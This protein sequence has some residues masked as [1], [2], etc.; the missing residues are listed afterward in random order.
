MLI[1]S[2]DV[3]NIACIRSQVIDLHNKTEE[4]KK[5]TSKFMRE[6]MQRGNV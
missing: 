3:S 5:T 4:N 2:Q 6:N 1:E